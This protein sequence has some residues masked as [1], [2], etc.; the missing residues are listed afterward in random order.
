M[1]TVGV[2]SEICLSASST[3]PARST[4]IFLNKQRN[5]PLKERVND[6]QRTL[7]NAD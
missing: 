2:L 6:D 7:A 1:T 5:R 4:P 3:F